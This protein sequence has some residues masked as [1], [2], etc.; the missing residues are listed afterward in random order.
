[1]L[2]TVTRRKLEAQNTHVKSSNREKNGRST[3]KRKRTKYSS[4]GEGWVSQN[5]VKGG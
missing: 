2:E 3:R 1:M 5:K 4:G